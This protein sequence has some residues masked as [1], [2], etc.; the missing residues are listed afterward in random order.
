[1]VAASVGGL[2]GRYWWLLD[3][4]SHFRVQYLVVLA[5]VATILSVVR[6]YRMAAVYAVVAV[7]NL[8]FVLPMYIGGTEPRTH[9]GQPLRAMMINVHTSNRDHAAVIDSIKTHDPD[10]V[11]V[12]EVN[13]R[14]LGALAALGQ[15]FPYGV[16]HPR[17]DNFGIALLSKHPVV[18]ARIIDVGHIGLPSIL[19]LFEVRGASFFI[20]GTHTLPPVSFEYSKWRNEHLG[21]IPEVVAALDAPTL[22][23][24]DL[25][26]SPWSFHFRRL[27]RDSGL[28]DGS[29][30]HGVQP[31]WPTGMF[32]LRIPI[33][34]CLHSSGIDIVDMSVGGPVGS[35]HFPVVVDFVPR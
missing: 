28:R 6:A 24:G 19:A 21:A 12:E 27:L 18:D 29:K 17:D 30:G 32:P 3:L 35:D 9:Q 25:N 4:A 33:D 15:Q 11:I 13:Q 8:A 14:W 23:L 20:L 10:F 1:M 5:V 22:L 7:A 31:T 16:E 34:H 26:V 2:A